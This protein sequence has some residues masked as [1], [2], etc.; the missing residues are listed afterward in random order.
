M[1]IKIDV[2]KRQLD[3]V[4]RNTVKFLA[5][6]SSDRFRAM[7]SGARNLT[8]LRTTRSSGQ[9]VSSRSFSVDFSQMC[10]R[11]RICSGEIK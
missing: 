9:E 5:P 4:V 1:S 3:R 7:K 2:Y 11:D 10:I 8:V 6:L